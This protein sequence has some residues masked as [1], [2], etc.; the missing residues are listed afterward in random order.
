MT[1]RRYRY[2]YGGLTLTLLVV[3][4]IALAFG[5]PEGDDIGL[6]EQI[7]AISPVPRETVLR[8]ARIEV[9]MLIGYTIE[10][11]IDGFRVPEQEIFFVE[12]TG[13]YSW[14]PGID[15]VFVEWGRGE[16]TVVVKWQSVAGLPDVGEYEWTFRV[17]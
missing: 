14:G 15:R 6:P 13:V 17:F 9:D 12:G 7:E 1:D 16:H 2:V 4:A 10:I 11:W 5:S 3:V 8:Q